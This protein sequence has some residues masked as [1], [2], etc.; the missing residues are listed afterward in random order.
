MR[1]NPNV[2]F[3]IEQNESFDTEKL[4]L[5]KEGLLFAWSIEGYLDQELKDDPRYVKT[6]MRVAGRYNQTL[7]E[8]RLEYEK[9]TAEELKQFALPND[10]GED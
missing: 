2:S 8:H 9:C 10:E 7:Y 3:F 1:E 5:K 4:S 6:I